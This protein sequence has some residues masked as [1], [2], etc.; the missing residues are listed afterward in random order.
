E[1]LMTGTPEA[2]RADRR[3]QEIYTGTGVPEVE[4]VSNDYAKASATPIL[5]FERVNTFYG[6]SHV[7]HDATL[8]VREAEIVGLLGRNGAGK[9]TLLKTLAGLVP[10]ASGAIEYQGRNIAG[11]PA[12]DLARLGVGHVPPGRGL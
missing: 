9:S 4:H 1:V 6:K 2:V 3:V 12:P 7:L 8:D 5:R 11:L 10:L